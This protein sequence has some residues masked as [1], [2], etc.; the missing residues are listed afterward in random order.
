MTQSKLQADGG[1][2]THYIAVGHTRCAWAR[3]ET[4][5]EAIALLRLMDNGAEETY[6]VYHVHRSTL[7]D[8]GGFFIGPWRPRLVMRVDGDTVIVVSQRTPPSTSV[9]TVAL[10]PNITKITLPA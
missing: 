5:D 6:S 1:N 8:P 4:V 10:P 2:L 7:V 9:V 3:A